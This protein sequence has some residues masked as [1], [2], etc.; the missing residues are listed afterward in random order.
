MA[1]TARSLVHATV[2]AIDRDRGALLVGTSGSGKSDLAL[3]CILHPIF[4]SGRPIAGHL[5]SDDQVELARV[6]DALIARP[7]PAIAGRIEVRGL[8]IYSVSSLPEARIR[9]IVELARRDAVE[10]LP[11]PWPTRTLLGTEIPVISIDPH[12]A[13]AAAKLLFALDRGPPVDT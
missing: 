6:G 11:L 9:L 2:V 10:R 12:D 1:D 4:D 3:R 8:G 13:S 7:P 5:V